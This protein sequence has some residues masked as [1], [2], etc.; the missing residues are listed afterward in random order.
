MHVAYGP[1][2]GV[3]VECTLKI[4][5][6]SSAPRSECHINKHEHHDSQANSTRGCVRRD[7]RVDRRSDGY[8]D[9]GEHSTIEL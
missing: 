4:E 2:N 3:M 5:G 8:G 6:S 1:R 9:S 7:D